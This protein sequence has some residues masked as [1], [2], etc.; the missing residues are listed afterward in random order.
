MIKDCIIKS[1]DKYL[2]L[3]AWSI[4]ILAASTNTVFSIRNID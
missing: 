2:F 4:G 3:Q 1:Q